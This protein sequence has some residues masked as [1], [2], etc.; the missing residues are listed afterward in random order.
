ML[1]Q[2]L[3][4]YYCFDVINYLFWVM[5]SHY[6]WFL[7]YHFTDLYYFKKC[8]RYFRRTET[9]FFRFHTTFFY[10]SALLK[11]LSL[12]KNS[13]SVR[14]V[15]ERVMTTRPR[16]HF[17]CYDCVAQIIHG[18][19]RK[20]VVVD[21]IIV[22]IMYTLGYRKILFERKYKCQRLRLLFISIIAIIKSG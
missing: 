14:V 8:V 7:R 22:G 4:L 17:R 15:G 21:L 1:C 16:P 9:L 6:L 11:H 20:M 12:R 2:Q 18:G 10:N 3:L 19:K 13:K 5:N